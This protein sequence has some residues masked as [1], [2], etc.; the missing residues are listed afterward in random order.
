MKIVLRPQTR[1]ANIQLH[2]IWQRWA[3]WMSTYFQWM[4]P[5]APSV[6]TEW[7]TVPVKTQRSTPVVTSVSRRRLSR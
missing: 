6:Q 1:D 5:V 3:Y 2:R 7:V 4:R